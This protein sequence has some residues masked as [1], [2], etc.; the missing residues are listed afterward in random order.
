MAVKKTELYAILWEAANNLCGGVESARYKDYVL[1][2]LF[3]KYVSDRYKGERY[4]DYSVR[5]GASFEDLVA[6]KGKTDIGERVDKI[7]SA[8]LGENQLQGS[9]PDVSFNNEDELGHG[10]ELVDRVTKLIAVFENPAIDF[11]TNRAS[12]DDIIGDAYEYFMMKFAQESG[13]SKGQFYTP[14][15]VSRIMARLIGIANID[16]SRKTSWTLYEQG[17]GYCAFFNTVVVLAFHAF[18]NRRSPHAPGFVQID[19]PCMAST[20][21]RTPQTPQCGPGCSSTSPNKPKTNKSSSWKTPTEPKA[22]S[23]MRRQR[24]LSFQR[25]R[26]GDATAT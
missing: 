25:A 21:A 11:R 9:L 7:L 10:K 8:F 18:M 19:T 5:E 2:L 1:T 6:A 14:S 26:H 3:F 13:K 17:K 12:G 24:S 20:R 16:A 23:S 15:E 22:S 4:G